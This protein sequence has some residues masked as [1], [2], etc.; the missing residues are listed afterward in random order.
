MERTV[1]ET[2]PAKDTSLGGCTEPVADRALV[3]I[4]PCKNPADYR[5]S[6]TEALCTLHYIRRYGR[7]AAGLS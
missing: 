1:G 4:R 3:A 2:T 5:V 6:G 7:E